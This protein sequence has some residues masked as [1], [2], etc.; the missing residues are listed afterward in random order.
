MKI[1]LIYDFDGTL[2]PGNMQEYDFIPSLGKD[3]SDFWSKS[4]QMAQ[5]WD[6]DP[7]LTYLNEM[8]RQAN[9]MGVS[10]R[11]E[12]FMESGSKVQL[13]DG[14]QDWFRRINKYGQSRGVEIEHYIN[15]SG[16]KEMIEGT[17]IARYFKNIYACSFLYT[18][19]GVAYWPAVAVNY[20]TKTQF[21]FKIN[22][23]ISEVSDTTRINKFIPESEREIPFTNMIYIGDGTTDIPCMRL[24]KEKQGNAIAVFDPAAGDGIEGSIKQLLDEN[25]VN[26]VAPA[27]YSKDSRLDHI[28]KAI[29]DSRVAESRLQE[30]R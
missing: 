5:Q 14:V 25:R 9:A 2:S 27:D 30:L 11:R 6:A 22:K 19:D 20:T 4:S 17:P 12:S 10:L 29:I 3:K 21:L 13:F 28:V 8:V 23:G 26:F 18:V 1:A 16:I 7:I 15:S 24:V